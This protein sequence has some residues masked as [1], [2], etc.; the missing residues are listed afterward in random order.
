MLTPATW[1]PVFRQIYSDVEKNGKPARGDIFN[2]NY[3]LNRGLC[4]AA[5]ALSVAIIIL[6]TSNWQVSLGL[7]AVSSVYL[8][9]THRFGVHYAR[10]ILNQFLLLPN[11]KEKAAKKATHP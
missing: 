1:S 5:L 3:G 7:L 10:E 9:R 4:A 2:G 11:E 8:Y 6:S